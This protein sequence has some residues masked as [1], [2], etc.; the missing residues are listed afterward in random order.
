MF[1]RIVFC[2]I[3]HVLCDASVR[4]H[5]INPVHSLVTEEEFNAYHLAAKSDLPIHYMIKLVNDLF[6]SGIQMVLITARPDCYR[7]LT[8]AWLRSHCVNF[9]Q[10][11]MRPDGDRNPSPVLKA[12]QIKEYIKAFNIDDQSR[13]LLV[14]D[15]KDICDAMAEIGVQ[16]LQFSY[17]RHQDGKAKEVWAKACEVEEAVST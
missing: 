10:L 15:R 3:D 7:S 1:K 5:M 6:S 11:I 13:V 17:N 8:K 4:D 14:D 9:D 2:D 12:M 16:T